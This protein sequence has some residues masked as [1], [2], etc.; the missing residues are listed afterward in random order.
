MQSLVE[1]GIEMVATGL[2][3]ELGMQ[4]WMSEYGEAADLEIAVHVGLGNWVE[5]VLIVTMGLGK[6]VG[7]EMVAGVVGHGVWAGWG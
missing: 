1:V 2:A 5:F 6:L 3:V 4:S 7:L